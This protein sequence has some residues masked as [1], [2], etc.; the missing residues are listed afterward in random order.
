MKYTIL[1]FSLF[2]IHSINSQKDNTIPLSEVLSISKEVVEEIKKMTEATL[3]RGGDMVNYQ[4]SSMVFSF[5]TANSKSMGG[6]IKIL[7]FSIGEKWS[8]SVT[9]NVTYRYSFPELEPKTLLF[10]VANLKHELSKTII[11]AL[12]ELRALDQ[13]DRERVDEFSTKVT[14]AISKD[15]SAGGGF[16]LVPLTIDG[17]ADWSK[18]AVHSVTVNYKKS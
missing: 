3:E 4:P 11:S 14:F 1:L 10:E 8:K 6:G 16:N 12:Q 9:N 13:K 17:G 7:I 15:K 2:I 18:S 5:E